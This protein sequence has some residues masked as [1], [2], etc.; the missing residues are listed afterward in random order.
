MF[1]MKALFKIRT[2]DHKQNLLEQ[3]SYN[4]KGI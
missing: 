2:G 3:I 4:Y 1:K